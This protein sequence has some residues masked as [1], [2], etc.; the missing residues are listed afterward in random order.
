[1]ILADGREAGYGGGGGGGYK[2][3]ERHD[4]GEQPGKTCLFCFELHVVSKPNHKHPQQTGTRG[5]FPELSAMAS[6]SLK[7]PDT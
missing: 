3:V 6:R 4:G 2:Q 1:M 5:F 7:S